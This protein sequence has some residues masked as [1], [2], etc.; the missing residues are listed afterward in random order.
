MENLKYNELELQNYLK[1]AT[2]HPQLAQ[3]IFKWRTRMMNFKSNF[4][5]GNNDI[6][7]IFGCTH[8]DS[9]EDLLKCEGIKSTITEIDKTKFKYLDIFLCDLSKLKA[10]ILLLQKAF[11]V[12]ESIHDD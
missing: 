5:N 8:D 11:K 9:Q 7:C 2:I 10:T 3:N 1:V 6:S 12:R 4:K